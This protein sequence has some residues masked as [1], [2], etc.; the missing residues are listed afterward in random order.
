LFG[1]GWGGFSLST[2]ESEKLT[3]GKTQL[4]DP[5]NYYVET[6]CDFGAVG[7]VLLLFLFMKAFA[8][9]Y[10]LYRTG[11]SQFQ[12]GLG[13]AFMGTVLACMITNFFGDRFSYFI[14]GSYFWILWGLVEKGLTITRAQKT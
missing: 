11:R 8:S 5:H 3:V 7:L 10:R 6:L 4:T 12:K 13:F 14:L 9:G 2:P 1:T